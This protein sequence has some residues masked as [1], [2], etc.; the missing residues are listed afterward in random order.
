MYVDINIVARSRNRCYRENA[1]MPPLHCLGNYVAVENQIRKVLTRK[2]SNALHLL[3]RYVQCCCQ[4]CPSK[5][6]LHLH[7]KCPIIK[8]NFY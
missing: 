8:C 7:V 1:T 4:H 5:G 6:H 3:L 2:S